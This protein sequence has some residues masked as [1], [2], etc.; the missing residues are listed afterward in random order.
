M[1]RK[2]IIILKLSNEQELTICHVKIPYNPIK[3]TVNNLVYNL[4]K[5]S[6]C[7]TIYC[8]NIYFISLQKWDHKNVL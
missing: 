1:Q 7:I 4:T 3:V 6:M 5:V 2:Y 8:I